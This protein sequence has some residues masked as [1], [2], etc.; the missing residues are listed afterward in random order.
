[1]S[2][3]RSVLVVDDS[4]TAVM[5]LSLLLR[6]MG[7][8]VVPARS[9]PEALWLVRQGCPDAI[10][11]DLHMPEMDGL[12]F[13]SELRK[14]GAF[15]E[16]PVIVVTVDTDPAVRERC[17][18]SGCSAYLQKP[19]DLKELHAQ[20]E[21]CMQRAD[22]KRDHLRAAFG[23]PVTVA[24]SGRVGD[25]HAVTLS[26]GGIYLRMAEP[27]PSGTA[28]TVTLPVDGGQ[29]LTLQGEALYD[30]SV[31]GAE[32][33]VDPGVAIVFVNLSPQQSF[34][35]TTIVKRLLVAN[36]FQEIS[37]PI[38]DLEDK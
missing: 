38:L 26:E 18:Q 30:K 4:P 36:L 31:Y 7:F 10:L 25:C 23:R 33:S 29:P 14:D 27:F 2:L 16:T 13:L 24:A 6:R 28:V 32:M 37:A 35:L 8:R 19:V 15:R 9:G 5:Y 34:Q 1:M 12:A 21:R 22:S 20:I 11:L 3:R 17:L